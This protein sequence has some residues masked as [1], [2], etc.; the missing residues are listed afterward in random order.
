MVNLLA[1]QEKRTLLIIAHCLNKTGNAS[2]YASWSFKS[3]SEAQPA[4]LCGIARTLAGVS[5][6]L[7][8][9]EGLTP[10]ASQA[11]SRAGTRS[12]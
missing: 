5:V 2:A 7:A 3:A 10:T 6:S 8:L 11:F 12:A 1:T 4:F 9:A